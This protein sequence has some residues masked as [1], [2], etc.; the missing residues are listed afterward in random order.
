MWI[1]SGLGQDC[2]RVSDD[3]SN[4]RL[5]FIWG[6]TS[7]S[8][9]Q[10]QTA[11]RFTSTGIMTVFYNSTKCN[12]SSPWPDATP[13][14]QR[15]GRH[16]KFRPERPRRTIQDDW[17]RD[18]QCRPINL[19][20]LLHD[21]GVPNQGKYEE[22]KKRRGGRFWVGGKE[23]IGKSGWSVHACQFPLCRCLHVTSFQP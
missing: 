16:Q 5:W 3:N 6:C 23:F 14:T 7:L 15:K 18:V 17:L 10:F 4:P 13:S 8:L 11:S 19:V 12:T 1:G 20:P 9:G 22:E 21:P 2:S